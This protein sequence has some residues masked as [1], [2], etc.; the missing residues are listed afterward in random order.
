MSAMIYK[1]V[2]I[3]GEEESFIRE[4]ELDENNTLLDF[5]KSIQE[6][7]E[8]DKSHLASFFTT[9]D[10]WEKEEEFT[11]FEMGSAITV[12]EEV[13]ID[14]I[15]INENQKLI[16]VFDF[17]NERVFFIENI[18]TVPEIEGREYPLCTNSHG[19]PPPQIVS[20]SSSGIDISD[21]DYSD[22]DILPDEDTEL[23]DFE[24]IDD[25]EEM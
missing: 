22:N 16:Y 4:F 20:S 24:N 25:F 9:T 19:A 11:L 10:N 14:D 15:L 8:Y 6:E 3:S 1:F 23:P 5:H 7:L 17:F 2:V 18:G 12:M 13:I 21:D